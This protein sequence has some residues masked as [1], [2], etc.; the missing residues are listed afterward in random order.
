[1][2]RIESFMNAK[3]PRRG[4]LLLVVLSILVLFALVGLTF[5]VAAGAF[6]R[7]A[8]ANLR[9]DINVGQASSE[10]D[11]ALMNFLRGPRAGTYTPLKGQELLR[12]I[13]GNDSA[14]VRPGTD[15]N[16]AIGHPQDGAATPADI[17][18]LYEIILTDP[19][20]ANTT[21]LEDVLNTLGMQLVEEYYSG[22]IVTFSSG[23]AQG[24]SHRV[25][26]FWPEWNST[27]GTL[28]RVRIV[29]DADPVTVPKRVSGANVP[30]NGDNF[31]LND[32]PF[33]GTGYGYDPTDPTA[34]RKK[35]SLNLRDADGDPVALVPN[36]NAAYPLGTVVHSV[37]GDTISVEAGGADESYDAPDHQNMFLSYVQWD[38][39]SGALPTTNDILPSFHRQ[40]LAR[41]WVN[42]LGDKDTTFGALDANDQI[43]LFRDPT[44]TTLPVAGTAPTPAH[45]QLVRDA[46]RKIILRPLPELHPNFDGSNPNFDIFGTAT[47]SRWDI[48]NDL[49]GVADSIWIDIGL[50][51]KT[52]RQGR[53]Y[54][55]L[56]AILVKDMDG[57]ININA[58]GSYAHFQQFESNTALPLTNNAV[59]NRTLMN[60]AT[61]QL[62]HGAYSPAWSG[63]TA[64]SM[65]LPLGSGYGPAEVSLFGI[66]GDYTNAADPDLTDAYRLLNARYSSNDLIRNLASTANQVLDPATPGREVVDNTASPVVGYDDERS[67]M[68]NIGLIDSYTTSTRNLFSTPPDRLGLGRMYIDYAGRPR[69][70]PA[71]NP[72]TLASQATPP[73]FGQRRN[74][75]YEMDL[76]HPSRYDSPFSYQELERV[77]RYEEY[78]S[79][80]VTDS[81]DRIMELAANSLS[82]S[83]AKRRLIT[84]ASFQVP[85]TNRADIPY[86]LR[87]ENVSGTL[88]NEIFKN[89]TVEAKRPAPTLVTLC[90][91]RLRR[92]NPSWA[93]PSLDTRLREKVHQLLP[94][95]IMR[96]EPFDINRL[97]EAPADGN[98]N[99][100]DSY[101]D[102]IFELQRHAEILFQSAYNTSGTYAPQSQFINWVSGTAGMASNS[103]SLP[104]P[105]NFNNPTSYS[106]SRQ[107]MARYLYVMMLLLMEEDYRFPTYRQAAGAGAYTPDELTELTRRRIAQWAI[108]VVDFRDRDGVMTPFEFDLYPFRDDESS[109]NP[110]NVNGNLVTQMDG[111]AGIEG[112]DPSPYRRVVWGSEAPDLL[113]SETLAFHDRGIKDTEWDNDSQAKRGTA[114]S[115]DDTLDQ[116]R[117]PQGSLFLEFYNPRNLASNNPGFSLPSELYQNGKLHLNRM[118]PS[119]NSPVWRVL[120]VEREDVASSTTSS[121]TKEMLRNDGLDTINFQPQASDR[122]AGNEGTAVPAAGLKMLSTGSDENYQIDRIIYFANYASPAPANDREFRNQN[123]SPL[124]LEPDQYFVVAPRNVTYIGANPDPMATVM[125]TNV[126]GSYS[127]E[128]QAVPAGDRLD[129]GYGHDTLVFNRNGSLNDHPLQYPNSSTQSKPNLA[130]AVTMDLP[131]ATVW[132]NQYDTDG[133]PLGIG[134]NIS[135]PLRD[136]YYQEPT[137]QAP[138]TMAGPYAYYGDDTTMSLPDIPFET[139]APAA[140]TEDFPLND[141]DGVSTGMQRTGTYPDPSAGGINTVQGYKSAVLQRLAN[142]LSDFHATLNPYITLDHMPIDLTVFNGEDNPSTSTDATITPDAWDPSEVGQDPNAATT[143][144]FQ[145]RERGLRDNAT[146]NSNGNL[147]GMLNNIAPALIT[148]PD[149]IDGVLRVKRPEIQTPRDTATFTNTTTMRPDHFARPVIHTLGYVNRQMGV[150][151]ASGGTINAV[152]RGSPNPEDAAYAPDPITP[153][154]QPVINTP[155]SWLHWANSPYVSKYDLMMVPSSSPQRML[156]EYSLSKNVD[157]FS[158]D[159]TNDTERLTDFHAPYQHLFNFFHSGKTNDLD[160]TSTSNDMSAQFVRIFDYI[161]V[162]SRFN[163]TKKW[164]DITE[165]NPPGT[166][167]RNDGGSPAKYND[168]RLGYMFPFNRRLEFREP[169][170]INLN[171]ICSET[172]YNS[173]FDPDFWQGTAFTFPSWS[174][175][176]AN[177]R[178]QFSGT[179]SEYPSRFSHPYR[180]SSAS[181]IVPE[182]GTA[183]SPDNRLQLPPVEATVLRSVDPTSTGTKSPLFDLNL[184]TPAVTNDAMRHYRTDDNPMLRYQAYQRLGNIAGNQSNV[185]AVW[186][187]IGYF[188]VEPHA[189][190]AD[191][192][193]G[194]ALGQELGNDTGDINRHRA[195]YII[196]RSIPVGYVP[197]EDLNVEDTI[198]LKRFIE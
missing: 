124:L 175:F 70:Q 104:T 26:H 73:G 81:N 16:I 43:A 19:N 20:T 41:Y 93:G 154:P 160:G 131:D 159:G 71:V 46:R 69:F 13:W 171:T 188:E 42:Y 192:P 139:D 58:Q 122:V 183:A 118:T 15:L 128:I 49:D 48:D 78:D 156:F 27:S 50:P 66:F 113:L 147:L 76:L 7:G 83:T 62:N 22:S 158:T 187:T 157:P 184:Q 11:A 28:V 112:G 135:E 108:N 54:K 196:D 117:I 4:A 90:Q 86:D 114:M 47:N 85:T 115:D 64:T 99:D 34:P 174:E 186:I 57:L 165:F 177:R 173:I 120:I 119:G 125:G 167:L 59:G 123:N 197:G 106:A 172:V 95:E 176:E 133:A 134:L 193:D 31:V 105:V 189:V 51:M 151:I 97:L 80:S 18:Q 180:P 182:L 56:A 153:V 132:T 21:T 101:T 45:R 179:A 72:A 23:L 91:E 30:G 8:T 170:K 74:D 129:P 130:I 164:F 9:R 145:S 75:P 2:K 155:Y 146:Q 88:D 40:D 138:G 136:D 24:Q 60:P 161:H 191:H 168:A 6:N 37:T 190:D 102:D 61:T 126:P 44:I 5:V 181:E 148:T 3:Q 25:M 142:P 79:G 163:G 107:L 149:G 92:Q 111:S 53:R 52:D 96:G 36:I 38:A 195:F 152:Y 33:N 63:G 1:M 144:Y 68:D 185:F 98:D 29:V 194:W 82:T 162:P 77:L 35:R 169:G 127:F 103:P 94:P 150:P 141:P 67:R 12:D 17:D 178:G 143:V 198:M 87:D 65:Q 140:G 116:Y 137:H 121:I 10:A 166:E 84:T 32:P 39:A 109:G 14:V 89:K 55:P 100:S 110:W